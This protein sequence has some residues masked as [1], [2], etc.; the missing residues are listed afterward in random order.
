MFYVMSDLHG[1]Y[2]KYIE[3]LSEIRLKDSDSL[4]INGDICDKGPSPF[5]IIKDALV[6]CNIFPIMGDCDYRALRLL[7]KM[8]S[9]KAKNDAEYMKA[10]AEWIRD[11]GM[12]TVTEFRTLSD[13]DCEDA[14]E[15]I[16]DEFVAYDE[17][18]AGDVDYLLVHSGIKDFSK[19][20]SLDSYNVKSFLTCEPDFSREY[21]DDKILVTGH[22]PTF[23]IDEDSRGRI[24]R[25][26][27]QIG[28]DCGVSEGEVLAC[29]CLDTGKEY[30]V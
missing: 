17:V 24:Y 4:F 25:R 27:G 21:F 22:T 10:F 18:K 16:K 23:M 19:N 12:T 3:M 2:D 11:G 1:N 28:I 14:L 26:N 20:K 30:Y 13:E 29:L 7:S 6:R 8:N 5:K 15:F 9:D